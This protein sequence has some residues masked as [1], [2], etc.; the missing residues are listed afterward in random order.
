MST[1]NIPTIQPL[2]ADPL[3][4][5][6]V[7]PAAPQGEDVTLDDAAQI[8]ATLKP[9]GP[10]VEGGVE[11]S[12]PQPQEELAIK[13]TVAS[14]SNDTKKKR[15]KYNT[16]GSSSSSNSS[17]NI[18][19]YL[20]RMDDSQF[21]KCVTQ[22]FKRRGYTVAIQLTSNHN[23]MM[24]L[25]SVPIVPQLPPVVGGEPNM[26][27]PPPA[28]VA[29]TSITSNSKKNKSKNKQSPISPLILPNFPFYPS[30]TSI[31]QKNID[32]WNIMF[33]QLQVYYTQNN[34]NLPTTTNSSTS[35]KQQQD[36]N[37]DPNYAALLKWT[38]A[39]L[40]LWKRMRKDNKHNLSLDRISKLHSLNFEAQVDV[41]R[42]AAASVAQQQDT[43][44]AAGTSFTFGG[45]YDND[46]MAGLPT[47]VDINMNGGNGNNNAAAAAASSY[48]MNNQ[49]NPVD[50]LMTNSSSSGKNAQ[51]WQDKFDELVRYKNEHG[52]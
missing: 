43:T 25:P 6:A 50:S 39:Q 5:A 29:K 11:L 47:G 17:G 44:V 24:Q 49:Q 40:A 21:L 28:K 32:A 20:K 13:P 31:T 12:L 8:M 4:A 22:D 46:P 2:T 1:N 16:S 23:W 35:T 34:G 42:Y 51:K 27:L 48:N 19:K 52:E 37:N 33:N 18:D 41:Q 36:N 7:Q 38:K 9:T 45:S 26:M 3:A 15:K 30:T 14:T 10:S